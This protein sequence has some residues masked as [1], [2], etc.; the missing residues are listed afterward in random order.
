MKNFRCTAC[1]QTI[2]FENTLC[3]NC[4]H[5]LGFLPDIC[6]M[7]AVEPEGERWIALA[8]RERGGIGS[9]GI[10]SCRVATG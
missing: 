9:A 2:V 7:T 4:S 3:R 10:G 8:A 6:D 1:D 5:H